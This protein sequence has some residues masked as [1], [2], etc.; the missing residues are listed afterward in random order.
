ME[1]DAEERSVD[2]ETAVI[3]DEAEFSEFVHEKI[4]AR[5]RGADHL[6]EHLLRNF[7]EHTLGLVFL[8]VARQ[9]QQ[10]ACQALLAGIEELIDQILLDAD[11][12]RQHERDETVGELVFVVEDANHLGFFNDER[13]GGRD[14]HGR[15]HAN[16]L[17]GETALAK[18]IAGPENRHDGLFAALIDYRKPHAA[19]LNVDDVVASLALREDGFLGLKLHNFSGYT[20]G[21]KKMLSVEC[22]PG[23]GFRTI[24]GFGWHS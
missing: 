3:L 20:G 14:R 1:D 24:G 18:K 13:S 19:F 10:R 5:A 12:A 8:A 21:I 16:R 4:H 6:G 11:I 17:G 9:E 23:T 7:G 2:L 15:A 22:S